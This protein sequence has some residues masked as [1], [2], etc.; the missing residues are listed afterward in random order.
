MTTDMKLLATI[1]NLAEETAPL[2][3]STRRIEELRLMEKSYRTLATRAADRQR[4]AGY[5]GDY[6]ASSSAGHENE[7][8]RVCADI[9]RDVA[10]TLL[11]LQTLGGRFKSLRRRLEEELAKKV[12]A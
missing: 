5:N 9:T 3:D 10:E 11:S 1:E 7:A 12:G 8:F 6:A 2:R 4:E